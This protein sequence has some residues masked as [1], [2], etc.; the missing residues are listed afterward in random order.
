M[1][2]GGKR[3]EKRRATALE[4]GPQKAPT[5]P[6]AGGKAPSTGAVHT[7]E[8]VDWQQL[9]LD[10]LTTLLDEAPEMVNEDQGAGTPLLFEA[11]MG[12]VGAVWLLLRRGANI[13]ARGPLGET[14]LMWAAQ[15]GHLEVLRVLLKGGADAEARNR[16][17][18]RHVVTVSLSLWKPRPHCPRLRPLQWARRLGSRAVGGEPETRIYP[19]G[20]D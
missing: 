18:R 3:G 15:E 20:R 13:N 11:R 7:L 19:H 1:S 16:S 12:D 2:E 8:S 10:S 4:D 6:Q 5:Q 14:A 17:V 9:Y